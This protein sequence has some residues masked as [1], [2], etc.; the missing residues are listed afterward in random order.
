MIP[1][2]VLKVEPPMPPGVLALRLEL[3]EKNDADISRA[4]EECALKINCQICFYE[5]L[6]TK[7]YYTWVDSQAIKGHGVKVQ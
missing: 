1:V 3:K 6:C 2:G 7:L 4:L 5:R